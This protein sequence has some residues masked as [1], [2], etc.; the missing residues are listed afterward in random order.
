MRFGIGTYRLGFVVSAAAP[1]LPVCCVNRWNPL[2]VAKAFVREMK[3]FS[4][5]SGHE[6]DEIGAGTAWMLRNHMR[7][8]AQLR[9]T[10][11]KDL[12]TL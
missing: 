12:F 2:E 11:V 7:R 4:K 10:S 8:G 1:T 3:L 6:A 9:V 5:K